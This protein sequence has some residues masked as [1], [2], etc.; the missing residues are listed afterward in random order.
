MTYTD[1]SFNYDTGKLLE[2]NV[3]RLIALSFID[4]V[5]SHIF[6]KNLFSILGEAV[7]WEKLSAPAPKK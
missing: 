2:R 3:C 7:E 6:L 4:I 5:P 1:N